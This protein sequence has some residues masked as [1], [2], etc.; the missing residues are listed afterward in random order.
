MKKITNR[1]KVLIGAGGLVTIGILFYFFLLP[2]LMGDQSKSK[3][4]LKAKQEEL[5]SIEQ[6]R[7]MEPAITEME[8]NMRNQLG[9]SQVSFKRIPLGS[10]D[11]TDAIIMKQLAQIANQSEIR[12][13]EQLD[14]KP[15]KNKKSLANLKPD[16][17]T[18]IST[19]DNLY[20]S[21]ITMD[22]NNPDLVPP[23]NGKTEENKVTKEIKKDSDH[24]D[25]VPSNP[26]DSAE[27]RN[28]RTDETSTTKSLEFPMIPK[29]IP[30]EAKQALIKFVQTHNGQTITNENVDEVV[31][32]SGI[33]DEKEIDRIKS[34]LKTYGRLVKEKKTEVVGILTKLGMLKDAKLEDRAGRFTAKMVFKSDIS[35]LIRLLYNLQ[36]S[37]RWVKVEGIQ[38]TMA[39][40]QKSLLGVELSMTAT[41]VYD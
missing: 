26:P 13:I 7:A 21:Q 15:D 25:V 33:K 29:D 9:Y 2:V 30:K 18:L 34:R 40:R 27:L 41:A 4:D 23:S 24:P 19:V 1:E 28:E 32:S 39:D 10:A 12:E 37:A 3:S 20:M 22:N 35:Q 6:L 31:S 8:K 17:T 11:A 36:T 38:I 5:Q 16:Q 14:V